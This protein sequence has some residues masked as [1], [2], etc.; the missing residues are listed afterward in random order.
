MSCQED[1]IRRIR[2]LLEMRVD[3]GC[4]PAEA[5]RAAAHVE[6]LLEEH[7][8][9]LF[10]VEARTFDEGITTERLPLEQRRTSQ[11]VCDL[12]F[13]VAKPH[14]CEW[15]VNRRQE[16]G[17]TTELTVCFVG[18]ASDAAV[19]RYLYAFLSRVLQEMADRDGRA[20]GR[21]GHGLI[22]FRT[23]YLMAAAA[24]VYRRLREERREVRA[25]SASSRAL[26]EVKGQA[27]QAFVRRQYPDLK[28]VPRRQPDL[29]G[30]ALAA[31]AEAARVVELRKGLPGDGTDRPALP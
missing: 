2:K 24:V 22:R 5:A 13:A 18:H 26:V 25:G 6:R 19:A 17:R 8:L 11:W 9:S 28:T 30:E 7:Q 15:F 10:D 31:G 3:R 14:D 16:W 12:A 29:D 27:V 4:T 21:S 20:A 1:V 23:S